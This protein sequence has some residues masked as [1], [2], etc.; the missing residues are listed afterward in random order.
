MQYNRPLRIVLKSVMQVQGNCFRSRYLLLVT[1]LQWF[2][3]AYII[4]VIWLYHKFKALQDT[5]KSSADVNNLGSELSNFGLRQYV[6]RGQSKDL[7]EGTTIYSLIKHGVILVRS[8]IACVPKRI[9]IQDVMIRFLDSST[10]ERAREPKRPAL[11]NGRN[12]MVFM[13][14]PKISLSVDN[15]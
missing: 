14:G 12:I 3:Q 1:L 6:S 2:A 5:G 9:S 15:S 7:E 8:L 4:L 11:C 10:L 13:L